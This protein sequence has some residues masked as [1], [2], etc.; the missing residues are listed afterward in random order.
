M[1]NKKT[2]YHFLDP[3]FGF[4]FVEYFHEKAL[5]KDLN[6]ILVFSIKMLTPTRRK[7]NP[8]KILDLF[9]LE[10]KKKNIKSKYI[11]F[12]FPI[13]FV[14]N[15]D[16]PF[17][18]NK[19]INNSYG[20]CT[21]FNQIFKKS[22]IEKLDQFINL[23]TSL[24]PFYRGPAPNY[25]CIK[26]GE[27]RTGFTLHHLTTEIDKGEILYQ[28]RVVIEN[29]DTE[30]TLNFKMA[31]M[32]KSSVKKYFDFLLEKKNWPSKKIT[33]MYQQSVFYK[34]FPSK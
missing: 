29:N 2:L 1:K 20:L 23:H 18:L 17:F 21:G 27:K 24:L 26:N 10:R 5:Q 6:I 3:I 30:K 11:H 22:L 28:E 9:S 7:G 16:S 12:G 32:A 34:S 13:I 14:S 15:V 31:N 25:W 4:P 33:P 19:I 8:L